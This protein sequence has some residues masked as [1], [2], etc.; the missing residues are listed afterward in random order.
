MRRWEQNILASPKHLGVHGKL[1]DFFLGGGPGDQ[2]QGLRVQNHVKLIRK[3]KKKD[4]A[5]LR[6]FQNSKKEDEYMDFGF[7][8]TKL[9]SEPVCL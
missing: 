5:L 6:I 9:C 4:A 1:C 2:T 8:Q 7:N 3:K